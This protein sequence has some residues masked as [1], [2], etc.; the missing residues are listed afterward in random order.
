MPLRKGRFAAV[1]ANYGKLKVTLSKGS[2]ASYL[3]FYLNRLILET[4]SVVAA[5]PQAI[6]QTLG[7]VVGEA[8]VV[9]FQSLDPFQQAQISQAIPA[10][11]KVDCVVYP[12]TQAELSEVVACAQRNQWRVL[13]CGRG[14]KLGWGGVAQNIDFIVSTERLNRLVE[15]AA[16]DLTVTVEAGVKFADLQATLARTGQFLPLDPAYSHQAT[17][18]GI[19]ATR[20][21]GSL[22]HRYGGVRDLGL[23]VTFV[24]ADGQR[25]KAGGRVVKNVAGY[26]LTK[27]LCGS[28]GTLGIIAEMTLRLYPLPEASQTV[29]LT[30]TAELIAQ[31]A[32]MLATANL[33]PTAVDLLSP[34]VIV[35]LGRSRSLALVVRFQ[36]VQ[37]SVTQQAASLLKTA[38]TLGLKGEALGETEEANFWQ[39]M[40][41]LFWQRRESYES[42][43]C[44]VGVLPAKAVAIVT[45]MEAIAHQYELPVK[46]LIHIGSGLGLVRIASAEP[47][48]HQAVLAFR[49]L[50]ER[51]QGQTPNSSPGQ[52][53][54]LTVLE[55]PVALKQQIEVWGYTGNALELM[56]KIKQQFDPQN[57][58][59]SN[60]FVG[61]I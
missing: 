39:E 17:V 11:T 8:G 44:K 30:G 13:P 43:L 60:R 54:F 16:G 15:H 26:D 55:A 24:R 35:S 2:H 5:S 10:K 31:A 38:H 36:S 14:T 41:N 48:V 50:C 25:V 1:L 32:K 61:N 9:S 53:G 51:P 7:E 28:F 42:I 22:R 34:Q 37:A 40:Q 20:D 58:L 47:A 46:S 21:A 19:F 45:A 4:Q 57:L 59:S 49:S 33:T 18:G 23:G 12:T 56:Q 27:L 6:A 3:F 29:L 52:R